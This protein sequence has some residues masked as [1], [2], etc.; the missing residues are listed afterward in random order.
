MRNS[1]GKA[2]IALLTVLLCA[3]TVYA[4]PPP[5]EAGQGQVASVGD[6]KI[7]GGDRLLVGVYDDPKI[8]PMDITVTPDGKFS[9]PLLGVIVAGG[10]TPEQLRVEMETKLR[11]FVA[12]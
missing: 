8:P 1:T 10:K 11:K 5:P 2:R 7:H 12:E 3:G 6:Y 4:A 9:F